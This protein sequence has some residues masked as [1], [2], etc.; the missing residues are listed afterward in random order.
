MKQVRITIL[1]LCVAAGVSLSAATINC[2]K[3]V[4]GQILYAGQA[5]EIF[6]HRSGDMQDRVRIVLKGE[7]PSPLFPPEGCHFHP[8]CHMASV[9]C[10][11]NRPPLREVSPGHLVACLRV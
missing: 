2:T 9:E 7:V 6:W 3:P 1:I 4:Q 11:L 5:Y 10:S 8:R